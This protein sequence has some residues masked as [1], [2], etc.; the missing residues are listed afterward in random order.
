MKTVRQKL[1]NNL[2]EKLTNPSKENVTTLYHH[3]HSMKLSEE[4]IF[5][6]EQDFQG[7]INFLN[8]RADFAI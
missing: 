5:K 7:L 4:Y 3:V 6:T 8:Q 1:F 2:C